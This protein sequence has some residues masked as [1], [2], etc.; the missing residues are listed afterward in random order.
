MAYTPVS[1]TST[2]VVPPKK[3]WDPN[4]KPAGLNPADFTGHHQEDVTAA[5]DLVN[6]EFFGREQEQ[7]QVIDQIQDYLGRDVDVE[8]KYGERQSGYL[9]D[10]YSQL[11][12]QLGQG[13]ERQEALYKGAGEQVG[14]GYS[15]A[16]GE[17]Q[18]AAQ[19]LQASLGNS[20]ERLGQGAALTD[21]IARL[22][23]EMQA[24]NARLAGSKAGAVGNLQTLGAT[25]VGEG[26][27][28]IGTSQKE[29]VQA[30]SDVG[31]IVAKNIG[32]LQLGAQE[33]TKKGLQGLIDTATEKGLKVKSTLHGLKGERTERD[34]QKYLDKLDEE[35]KRANLQLQQR[36]QQFQ[37][38]SFAQEMKMKQNEINASAQ[39]ARA[40]DPMAELSYKI[41]LKE[42]EDMMS[43]TAKAPGEL[44][45]RQ[46]LDYWVK[47]KQGG[48]AK[49]AS[50]VRNFIAD[51]EGSKNK[52]GMD[53]YSFAV[54]TLREGQAGKKLSKPQK[55][56]MAE[57][58][59]KGYHPDDIIEGLQI[60]F[61]S[62]GKVK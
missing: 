58:K 49:F 52:A 62:Y 48:D 25:M 31:N 35:F 42:Y 9:E 43:P 53:P 16:Q 56:I 45:G 6:A 5:G 41:K 28:G 33:Q 44:T 40:G 22:N 50:T 39:K 36:S 32:S 47:T 46:G 8:Q 18:K 54:Q 7:R 34:R 60:Y 21:P 17:A 11:A 10:I 24:L 13:V 15:D 23:A 55:E 20:A 61:G 4:A 12:G 29:K 57:I 26:I 38:S 37:E 3:M 2:P 51:V 1:N 14:Q 27:K 19:S 59:A 30:Q